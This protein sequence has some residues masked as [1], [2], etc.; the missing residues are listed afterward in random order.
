VKIEQLSPEAQDGLRK[1]AAFQHD[2]LLFDAISSVPQERAWIWFQLCAA[3]DRPEWFPKGKWAT[4]Q[5]I[6]TIL[7]EEADA[8]RIR[9]SM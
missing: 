8:T 1:W 2:D 6:A 7:D 4:I 9:P 3:E 5:H